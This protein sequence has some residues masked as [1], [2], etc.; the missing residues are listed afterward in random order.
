M[1]TN[2][3]RIARMHERAAEIRKKEH[4]RKVKIVQIASMGASLAAVIVL[5]V[6]MPALSPDM[7]DAAGGQSVDLNA[8]IFAESG[9]LGYIVI[10]IIAFL[11][12][13][14]VTAFCFHL[15]RWQSKKEQEDEID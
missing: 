3:E 11:L 8:S 14:C 1:L 12:G 10:A 2:E 4:S 6:F 13:A 5:A 7:P 9:A 15:K